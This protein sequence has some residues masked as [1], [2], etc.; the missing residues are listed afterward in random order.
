LTVLVILH[1]FICVFLVF[2]IL[3]QPGKGEGGIGFGSSSQTIF[4]SR[5]AGN[6]LTKTTSICAIVFL[7]TSFFLTRS[8]MME[9][10]KSVIQSEPTAPSEK[11][12]EPPA[13]VP[14]A[15]QSNTKGADTKTGESPT[16]K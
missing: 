10:N 3:L 2:V 7:A 8:R 9:Y 1:I 11:K 13:S 16:K 14:A 6:F 4:G 5:G 15:P 12:T